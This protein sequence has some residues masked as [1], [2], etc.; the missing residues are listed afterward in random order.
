MNSTSMNHTT[1][2]N[3]PSKAKCFATIVCLTLALLLSL[4]IVAGSLGRFNFHSF[5]STSSKNG[6][7]NDQSRHDHL[8]STY[9]DATTLSKIGNDQSLINQIDTDIGWMLDDSQSNC[10]VSWP[11]VESCAKWYESETTGYRFLLSNSIPNYFVE[12]YCPFEAG[13]GYCFVG[14]TNSDCDMFQDMICPAQDGREGTN[15]DVPVAQMY[16][17]RMNLNPNPLDSDLP[18][19]FI[20][21]DPLIWSYETLPILIDGSNQQDIIALHLNGV[22]VKSTREAEGLNVD[23][24]G[25]ELHN[26]CG[27]YV[28]LYTVMQSMCCFCFV[29]CVL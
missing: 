28:M 15:G 6:N 20:S 7:N 27:G 3:S 12:E 9:L 16:L 1:I 4:I 18:Q 17:Y 5:L 24:V 23:L 22:M 29:A 26:Y 13:L 25:L 8:Y 14:D 21:K 10:M 19:N 2:T 11:D